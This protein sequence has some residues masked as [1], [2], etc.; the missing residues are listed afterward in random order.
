MIFAF[1][2]LAIL[3]ACSARRGIERRR[4]IRREFAGCRTILDFGV[5]KDAVVLMDGQMLF[6]LFTAS[7][8]GEGSL[9]NKA[10]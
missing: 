10:S 3:K 8:G 7:G 9:R 5:W 1:I 2:I 6:R 4:Q